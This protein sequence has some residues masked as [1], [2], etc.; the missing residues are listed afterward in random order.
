VWFKLARILLGVPDAGGFWQSLN[1]IQSTV[2]LCGR[3]MSS[4][5]FAGC[6]VVYHILPRPLHLWECTISEWISSPHF[7]QHQCD[8]SPGF[9]GLS[10]NWI[11]SKTFIVHPPMAYTITDAKKKSNDAWRV[12][13]FWFTIPTISVITPQVANIIWIITALFMVRLPAGVLLNK[14]NALFLHPF[15]IPPK[16][17]V[18]AIHVHTL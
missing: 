8:V 13:A 9:N 15:Q 7:P 16:Q 17:V 4:A 2:V 3:D 10:L 11:P 18:V 14:K 1:G 12:S 6:A 5:M